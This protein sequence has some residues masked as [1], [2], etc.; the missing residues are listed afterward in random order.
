MLLSP[1][2]WQSL[3]LLIL[4]CGGL[5]RSFAFDSSSIV[6][7]LRRITRRAKRAFSSCC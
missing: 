3:L 7:L 6:L 5:R 2:A 4:K 1:P